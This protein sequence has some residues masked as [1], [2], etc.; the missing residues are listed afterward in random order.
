[1]D[2]ISWKKH[3]FFEPYLQQIL[4]LNNRSHPRRRTRAGSARGKRLRLLPSWGTA[5]ARKIA[6]GEGCV[7][8]PAKCRCGSSVPARTRAYDPMIHRH[9]R[10]E[11][12]EPTRRQLHAQGRA[13][14]NFPSNHA[15]RSGHPGAS[16]VSHSGKTPHPPAAP[17]PRAPHPGDP[18]EFEYRRGEGARR[19]RYRALWGGAAATF[20][21]GGRPNTGVLPGVPQG[22]F[23]AWPLLHTSRVAVR[24]TSL[25]H[26][27]GV[28]VRLP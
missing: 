19:A 8:C 17:S 21:T 13:I 27:S 6:G 5:H 14:I 22:T 3:D 18:P 15:P 24:D 4:S 25:R 12:S 23:R 28:Q 26:A 7:G 20:I 16:P 1:M 2:D 11:H 10:D 9:D